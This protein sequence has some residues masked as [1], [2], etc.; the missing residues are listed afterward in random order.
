MFSYRPISLK[1]THVLKKTIKD[2][3]PQ[4]LFQKSFEYLS[5]PFSNSA[6]CARIASAILDS[7]GLSRDK[8]V[9]EKTTR[10]FTI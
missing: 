10:R 1:R 5:I 3:L 6:T 2:V 8:K 7:A 4:D 9:Q